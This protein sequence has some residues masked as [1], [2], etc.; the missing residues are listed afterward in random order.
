MT[1]VLQYFALYYIHHSCAHI[2]VTLQH[3]LQHT[4]RHTLQHTLQHTSDSMSTRTPPLFGRPSSLPPSHLVDMQE[5][6]TNG[7]LCEGA[8]RA[9][10]V[11]SYNQ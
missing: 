10:V 1:D 9:L 8:A 7:L 2:S 6:Q 11:L 5:H 3:T 4:L